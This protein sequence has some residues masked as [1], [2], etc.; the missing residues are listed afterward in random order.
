MMV[1]TRKYG[2]CLI[3]DLSK[4]ELDE[5]I[6]R[7]VELSDDARERIEIFNRLMDSAMWG[8]LDEFDFMLRQ[9]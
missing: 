5:I 8:S 4:V 2:R 6:S 9:C 3:D 1:L 7:P